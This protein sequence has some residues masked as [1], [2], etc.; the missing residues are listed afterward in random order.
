MEDSFLLGKLDEEM[1]ITGPDGYEKKGSVEK[2]NSEIYI[3]V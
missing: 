1:Y 2:L 3:L